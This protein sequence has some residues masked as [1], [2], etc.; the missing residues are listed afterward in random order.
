MGGGWSNHLVIS[1]KRRPVDKMDSRSDLS[2]G[3]STCNPHP[4]QRTSTKDHPSSSACFLKAMAGPAMLAKLST[5]TCLGST[6]LPRS[7]PGLPARPAGTLAGGVVSSSC[8][9]DHLLSDNPLPYS[10][11]LRSRVL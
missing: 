7:R 9:Q 11:C 8:S 6:S 2:L 10:S 5:G 4:N 1:P 3:L